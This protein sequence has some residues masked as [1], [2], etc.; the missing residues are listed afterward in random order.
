MKVELIFEHRCPNA[1]GARARLRQALVNCGLRSVWTEWQ[2]DDPCS[3][4]Y[5]RHRASPT[6]LVDGRDIAESMAYDGTRACRLYST[7]NGG[8]S[9]M[10][11]LA[12]IEAALQEAPSDQQQQR[13]P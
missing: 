1:D 13:Q 5:A 12:K 10:P 6:I 11:E 7:S 3:P 4:D 8:V 9:G 2:S